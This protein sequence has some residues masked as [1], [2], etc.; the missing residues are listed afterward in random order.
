MQELKKGDTIQEYMYGV[1]ITSV[2]EG[3][4]EIEYLVGGAYGADVWKVEV[5]VDV[6]IGALTLT[7]FS[8]LKALTKTVRASSYLQYYFL[9]LLLLLPFILST[10]TSTKASA[11]F[12]KK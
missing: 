5:F 6:F 11:L 8:M 1:V 10:A 7:L 9:L 12:P 2:T 4:R 3:G